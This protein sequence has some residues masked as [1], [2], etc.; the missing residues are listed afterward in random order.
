MFIFKDISFDYKSNV[1]FE[2]GKIYGIGYR[3]SIKSGWFNWFRKRYIF[4]YFKLL[5][6]WTI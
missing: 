1:R 2:L 5:Y 6:V 4:L 3:K